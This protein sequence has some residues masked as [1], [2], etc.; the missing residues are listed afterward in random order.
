MSAL[1]DEVQIITVLEPAMR[2]DFEISQESGLA[3]EGSEGVSL[4][5]L[6]GCRDAFG[7]APAQAPGVSRFGLRL[8]C[9]PDPL[10]LER[11]QKFLVDCREDLNKQGV[12]V[13]HSVDIF[14][15]ST[16]QHF[17]RHGWPAVLSL[18]V[19]LL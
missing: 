10:V 8:Q 17:F 13:S 15:S 12:S 7:S 14:D 2:G 6:R 18:S 3:Y 5:V 16:C 19:T 9:K 1:Q 4:L 11:T